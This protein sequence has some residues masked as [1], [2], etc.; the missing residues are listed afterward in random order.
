MNVLE[1]LKK[2]LLSNKYDG[3]F[4]RDSECGCLVDDLAP[5]CE[6]STECEAGYKKLTPNGESDFVVG[7]KNNN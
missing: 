6:L 5:C 3:L 4:H 7:P 2:W 1:I